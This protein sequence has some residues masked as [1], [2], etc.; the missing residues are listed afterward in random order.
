[1][2]CCP[3]ERAELEGQHPRASREAAAPAQAPRVFPPGAVTS[4]GRAGWTLALGKSSFFNPLAP[5]GRSAAASR[6]S[7]G[8]CRCVAL[9]L[10]SHSC[11]MKDSGPSSSKKNLSPHIINLFPWYI[12]A[13]PRWMCPQLPQPPGKAM[14]DEPRCEPGAGPPT[15]AP[16][17]ASRTRGRKLG[18]P[19]P[20]TKPCWV[21]GRV[22]CRGGDLRAEARGFLSGKENKQ[23]VDIF[24][25][26]PR[27]LPAKLVPV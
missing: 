18:F 21:C 17:G 5:A 25:H 24:S 6:L 1:M 2:G 11:L 23:R 10:P 22:R 3:R 19:N 15:L 27:G 9:N 7:G 13:V 4:V 16:G 12:P 14:P 8:G 20:V 26:H